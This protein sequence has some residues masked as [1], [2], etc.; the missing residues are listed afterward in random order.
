MLLPILVVA[1]LLRLPGV[2][3]GPP[4]FRQDE[5]TVAL[6]SQQIERGAFPIYFRSGDEALPPAF[7][8]M[9]NISGQLAGWGVG[10]PRLAAALCGIAAAVTCSLWYRQI[11]GP[12]WGLAGGLL[13]A[14]SFWQIVFSRQAVPAI[15]MAAVGGLGLWAF[16]RAAENPQFGGR[17]VPS[18]WFGAAGFAFGIGVYTDT[19]MR[20]VIPIAILIGLFFSYKEGYLCA[21]TDRRGLLLGLI[22]MLLVGAPLASYFW[23][24]P[25]TFQIGMT[26]PDGLPAGER[27][28]S[29]LGALLWSG[30]G[31]WEQN[32][33]GRSLFDPILAIWMLIGFTCTLRHPLR[34]HHAGALIWFLGFLAFVIVT[35]PG[36]HGQLLV[37]TP[38][39]FLFPLLAMREAVRIA[40]E[41][42]QRWGGIAITVVTLSNVGSSAW[43]I[44]DYFWEW[45][46]RPE[47]YQAFQG[48]VRDAVE[49]IAALPSDSIVVYFS[50]GDHGRIVRY[51]A[52][53]RPRRDFNDPATVPLPV[54][55]PAYLIAP[56]SADIGEPISRYFGDDH[57]I[58]RGT[59]PDGDWAFRMWF[60]DGR[61]RDALPYAAPA[62]F[63]E[64]GYELLG[65]EVSARETDSDGP[66]VNVVLV[67]R[68][69]AGSDPFRALVR[70]VPPGADTPRDEGHIVQPGPDNVVEGS[71]II[72]TQI[73]LPFPKTAPMVAD[74]QAA[75]QTLE[76][77]YLVPSGPG[78][79]VLDETHALLNAIGYIGPSQ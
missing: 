17:C 78:V 21:H 47:T 5:A 12:A 48:D 72:L 8:Y 14:T 65:F 34:S 54:D 41:R 40:C 23:A 44:Y 7:P 79:T 68:A 25:E 77:E 6:A 16:W 11:L 26:G 43:S 9:V 30:T 10:G 71:E 66:W 67:L 53:D 63:F 13:V 33:A 50:T 28:A 37:L 73:A 59:Q 56:A 27:M 4:G 60:V 42:G 61:T 55:G 52:P 39:L 74:L 18:G 62:V 24:H 1:A 22:V 2:T 35:A 36:D 15:T 76:R 69:P 51:L 38:V 57:L 31:N 19:G 64:G 70:L 32:I 58:A 75:L 3:S 20:A 29:T 45:A 46:P 49:E